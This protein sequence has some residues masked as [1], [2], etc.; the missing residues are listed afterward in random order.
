MLDAAPKEIIEA[1]ESLRD[2]DK[3]KNVVNMFEVSSS[4]L[5]RHGLVT[6]QAQQ[7]AA[8]FVRGALNDNG[9]QVCYLPKNPDTSSAKYGVRLYRSLV[10]DGA[11]ALTNAGCVD[12]DA[13]AYSESCVKAI[14][15]WSQGC[16]NYW[17]SA[18]AIEMY[19]R[20][21]FIWGNHNGNNMRELATEFGLSTHALYRIIREQ[22]KLR[23]R[24]LNAS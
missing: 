19:L 4:A 14:Q 15:H 21:K 1:I 9:G 5:E 12:H 18:R 2:S 23:V 24:S 13:F 22:K 16:T 11:D 17:P 20:D 6:D 8:V 3:Y 7:F 10:K